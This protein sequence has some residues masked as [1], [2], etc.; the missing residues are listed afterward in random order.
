M[1][2]GVIAMSCEIEE[3]AVMKFLGGKNGVYYGKV[4]ELRE[5]IRGWLAYIP[6]SFPHYT[7]HTIEHSEE[8]ISQLSKLLFKDDDPAQP[9]VSLSATEVYVVTAGAYL[10]DAGMVVSDKE[11]GEILKSDDWAKWTTGSGGGAKRL[12]EVKKFRKAKKPA[13]KIV[14]NFLADVQLRFLIAEFVRS[15]HHQRAVRVL[16]QHQAALGRFAFDSPMLLNT[17]N[18]VCLAHGL[19]QHELRD[20][21]RFPERRDI[22]G[23][24]VNVKFMA[25]LLRMGDLLDMSYDRACPL[26]LN[27]A[28]PLPAGS[29]AHWTQ[30]QA[31]TH[32]M[33]APDRIEITA[34]CKNQREHQVLQDWCQWLVD[35]VR[36]A[37][38]LMA[39][40][41]RHRNWQTPEVSLGVTGSTI[42]IRPADGATYI[43][44]RWVIEIDN[45]AV[46]QLLIR[47]AY[48]NPEVFIRE[49]IQNALD[50]NRCQMYTDAMSQGVERPE[51]P[52][53]FSEETRFGYPVRISLKTSKVKSEFSGETEGK[54]VLVVEDGGIGMDRDI[55]ERYF[56]QVGRS[57]Y[58]SE[59][60]RRAFK[61]VPTSRFG[62]GFL[63]VFA[64]SDYV[65]VETQKPSSPTSD[66]PLLLTLTG[67][68][69]YLLTDKGSRRTSGTRIEVKLRKQ[70]EHGKLTEVVTQW[71]RRVEFPVLVDDLGAQ[72]TVEA[73]RAED[74]A[75]EMPDIT[76]KGAKFVVRIFPID[77]PGIEGGLYVFAHITK[78][79]ES[80]ASKWWAQHS[81]PELHPKA[82]KPEFPE[83]LTCMHGISVGGE[84]RKG[85]WCWRVDYRG[86]NPQPLLSREVI[87][88][89]RGMWSREREIDPEIQSRWDEIM[90]EHLASSPLATGEDGWRYRQKLIKA[91]PMDSFWKSVDGTIPIS[92]GGKKKTVSWDE[93]KSMPCLVISLEAKRLQTH[94]YHYEHAV[95]ETPVVWD[96][97]VPGITDYELN[98]LS[99]NCRISIFKG[100]S[101]RNI[102]W[103]ASG[104]L[105]VDWI[106]SHE[107]DLLWKFK[108]GHLSR[109]VYELVALP[110]GSTVAVEIHNTLDNVHEHVLLNGTHPFT[111]WL[112]VA[113]DACQENVYGLQV[114][115]FENLISLCAE[116]I[117]YGGT[118][119]TN[120]RGYIEKWAR[121]ADLPADLAPPKVDWNEDL[122][123]L[124]QKRSTS[125]KQKAK[126]VAKKKVQEKKAVK[127]DKKKKVRKTAKKK[128]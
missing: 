71:C 32:F 8:I 47:D 119:I 52:T 3:T 123:L 75:Y 122:F 25:I 85:D 43:P 45:E 103:L 88:T 58:R 99:D 126:K 38:N 4:L 18:D 29:L 15:S 92:V 109:P 114:E 124:K 61:F 10:H 50:A 28:C 60:F 1:V 101:A 98:A 128:K 26:L 63:S 120:L 40:S 31:I 89:R 70:I 95:K 84:Y 20:A 65:V 86:E 107:R 90:R 76:E 72:T 30:Y 48:E 62:V 68:R 111:K 67:P 24:K 7:R 36:E 35:E 27:A 104:H 79:G 22:R 56:L 106:L 108:E 49:L 16:T 21:E 54:Q 112:V 39:R 37:G 6:Q 94:F 55:I 64:V 53:Q 87:M 97:S 125:K 74:F 100:R 93:V 121:I 59:E 33:V 118:Y 17:I 2:F 96:T 80:W 19:R 41:P 73:E 51:N 83:G 78:A 66:G 14:R 77:R 9:T 116:A 117:G 91:F 102:R 110:E 5:A 115:Q 12:A 57:Y 82:L 13:D 44:S 69:N 23:E 46:F 127:K 105:A 81:Y 42:T 34:E 11:K 113:R